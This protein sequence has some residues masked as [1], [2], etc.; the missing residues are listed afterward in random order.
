MGG[1]AKSVSKAVK[2][3]TKTVSKGVG[4]IGRE[5]GRGASNVGREVGIAADR[6]MKNPMDT[7]ATGGIYAATGK[8]WGDLGG[9]V[10]QGISESIGHVTGAN[11]QRKAMMDQASAAQAE[12]LR[13][14]R[15]ADA[16]AKSSGSDPTNILL[17]T[18]RGRKRKSGTAGV[19]GSGTQG[20]T[21]TG[22]Q[23]V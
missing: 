23:N 19:G 7:L 20:S 1:V 22:T 6:A 10:M 13:Q 5:A 14:S 16:L 17:G 15:V 18:N 2:D 21:G 4:D 12:A 8:N 9:G 3:T 11:A